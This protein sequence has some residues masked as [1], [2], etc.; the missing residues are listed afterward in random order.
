VN[1]VVGQG[2]FTVHRSLFTLLLLGIPGGECYPAGKLAI[3]TDLEGILAGPGQGDVEDQH[4]AR[5]YVDHAG[6]GL[7]ELYGALAA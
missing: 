7:P 1:Q 6:W 2:P 4:R 5:L 3:E